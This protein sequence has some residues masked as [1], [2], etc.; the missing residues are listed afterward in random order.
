MPTIGDVVDRVYRDWLHGPDEQPVGVTL[1]GAITAAATTWTVD[2]AGITPEEQDLL[3]KGLLLEVGSEQARITDVDLNASTVTV[4]RGV[5]GTTAATHGTGDYV[6]LSP[7]YARRSVFDAVADEVVRL[8]PDLHRETTTPITSASTYVEVPAGVLVPLKF[9]YQSGSQWRAGDVS[10][11]PDFP[12]SSTGKAVTFIGVPSGK[13][14]HLVYRGKFTR[15]T[16]ES[17][18]LADLGVEEAWVP[19][20][21]TGAAAALIASEDL[22]KATVEWVTQQLEAQQFPTGSSTRLRDSLL[23]YRGYLI[24]QAQRSQRA[25][26]PT[27]VVVTA[28]R[29]I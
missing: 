14:G 20:L 24:E 8:H 22:D 23:R 28:R 5:N 2:L 12:P 15:P 10:L 26:G 25:E 4:V 18:D 13:N 21:T 11:L 1:D 9:W 29:S 19:I 27:A 7:S 16:A 6:T 3:G 17:D